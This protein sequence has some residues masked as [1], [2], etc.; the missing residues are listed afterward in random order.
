MNLFL[1]SIHSMYFLNFN[2][3]EIL[4]S[5]TFKRFTASIDNILES[6]EDV[7]LTAA[8]EHETLHSSGS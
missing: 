3:T 5:S 2:S 6:L 8:G 7:D 1:F 4:D